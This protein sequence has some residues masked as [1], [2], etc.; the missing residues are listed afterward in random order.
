M[1]G[2]LELRAAVSGYLFFRSNSLGDAGAGDLFRLS[3]GQGADLCG[4]LHC[5]GK[6]SLTLVG[7]NRNAHF[8][9]GDIALLIGAGLSFTQLAFF[10]GRNLLAL[11]GLDLF[12]SNLAGT[13][14][15]KND[16]HVAILASG[17][18]RA[19]QDFFKLQVVMQKLVFHLLA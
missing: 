19:D 4:L 12:N 11:E 1:L 3:L 14:L 16:L 5:P 7:E 2:D 8:R 13:Q 10:I 17:G 6:V 18:G 15:V 9:F